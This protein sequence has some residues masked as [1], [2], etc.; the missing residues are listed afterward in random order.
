MA[1]LT[2]ILMLIFLASPVVLSTGSYAKGEF[3]EEMQKTLKEADSTAVMAVK[4]SL[5]IAIAI[6]FIL[7][8]FPGSRKAGAGLFMGVMMTLAGIVLFTDVFDTPMN[9]LEEKKQMADFFKK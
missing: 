3:K 1:K 8:I 4:A 9:T 7:I 2:S 6:S 5:Y